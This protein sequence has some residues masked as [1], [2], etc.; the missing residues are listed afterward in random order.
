M[1]DGLVARVVIGLFALAMLTL[2]AGTCVVIGKAQADGDHRALSRYSAQFLVLAVV[3]I[4]LVTL[5]ALS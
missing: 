1:I 5:L 2:I 3:E 4:T